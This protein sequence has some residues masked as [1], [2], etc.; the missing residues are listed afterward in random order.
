MN[1][2]ILD[3]NTYLIDRIIYILPVPKGLFLPNVR[4]GHEREETPAVQRVPG[5]QRLHPDAI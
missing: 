1:I 5:I 3:S 4:L 2:F